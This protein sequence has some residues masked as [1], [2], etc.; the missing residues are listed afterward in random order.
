MYFDNIFHLH[1]PN[2]I[3][4]LGGRTFVTKQRVDML[5]DDIIY[6]GNITGAN[7]NTRLS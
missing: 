4:K 1:V 3:A 6:Q 2:K 5:G 7:L